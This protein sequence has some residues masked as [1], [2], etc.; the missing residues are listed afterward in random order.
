M[1]EKSVI[2]IGSSPGSGKAMTNLSLVRQLAAAGQ[3]VEVCL[4]QDGVLAGLDAGW[5]KRLRTEA[6][7][8][9]ICALEE[10]LALRGFGVSDLAP[11]V[12]HLDHAGLVQAMLGDGVHVLGVL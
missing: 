8:T 5:A 3:V 2:L 11:A 6:P 4:L 9:T 12:G 1:S 10:D 7:G